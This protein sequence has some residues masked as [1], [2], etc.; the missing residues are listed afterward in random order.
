MEQEKL[1]ALQ[2]S[3]QKWEKL[4]EGN[5]DRAPSQY[6]CPLC[7]LY[8]RDGCKDCPVHERTGQQYCRGTPY[9]DYYYVGSKDNAQKE[10]DFLK[11]LLPPKAKWIDLDYLEKKE[12]SPWDK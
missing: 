1:V 6:T 10:L 3:I 12:V 8:H 7:I 9:M 5:G 11:S 2:E 4:A